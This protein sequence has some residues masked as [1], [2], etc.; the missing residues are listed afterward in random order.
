MGA[1]ADPS[2][3]AGVD[4]ALG[5]AELDAGEGVEATLVPAR[6][7]E[8]PVKTKIAIRPATSAQNH[9]RSRIRR[10]ELMT[11]VLLPASRFPSLYLES[12]RPSV[13]SSDVR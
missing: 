5:V 11:F 13:S 12:L 1:A 9:P 8:Q 10:L 3:P 7:V 4:G 2:A 6:F